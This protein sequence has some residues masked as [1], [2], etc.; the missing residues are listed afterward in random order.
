MAPGS[1]VFQFSGVAAVPSLRRYVIDNNDLTNRVARRENATASNDKD[2]F[3]STGTGIGKDAKF[4]FAG[5][6]Y[7]C[8]EVRA[9]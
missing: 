1:N 3:H 8:D 9:S 5:R 4:I 7:R 2:V 6:A